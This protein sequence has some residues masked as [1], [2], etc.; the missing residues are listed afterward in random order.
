MI[1][2]PKS[3]YTLVG[4]VPELDAPVMVHSL[5]GFMDA[6]SAGKGLVDHLLGTLDHRVVVSFDADALVDYRARRPGLTFVEDHFERY[7]VPELAIRLLSDADGTPFYLLSGPEPD[8]LWERFATAVTG[9]V[10]RLGVRLTMGVHGI[11]MAV[12]HTRPLGVTA[13]ATR[14]DL[15]TVVNPWRGEIRIPSS[16]ASLLE[17]RLG[18]AGHDAMG[19]VAHVPHYLAEAEYPDAS[20]VLLRAISA[21]TGLHLPAGELTEAA[22]QTRTLVQEQV[23]QSD[24]VARVV[25]ALERQ[26]DAYTS[27]AGGGGL[28]ADR[29]PMPSAEEIG[30][31]LER[32]LAELGDD[33]GSPAPS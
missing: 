30:A 4:D 13:H 27:G 26:F 16:A 23:D 1:L 22:G 10:E 11:P 17:L 9:L 14:R 12:P 7:A 15:V 29:S 2:D 6:G 5:E 33:D 3:L 19:F 32:F 25:R 20:L 18:H 21:A 31:E 8:V 24:E 28:L